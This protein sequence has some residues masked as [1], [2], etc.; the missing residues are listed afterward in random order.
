MLLHT[1]WDRHWRHPRV[2]RRT[3]PYL[4]ADG[5]EWLVDAGAALVGIDSVNI[6]DTAGSGGSAPRTRSCSRPASRSSST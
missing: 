2:R 6:D 5:G 4:T 1:G 3:H